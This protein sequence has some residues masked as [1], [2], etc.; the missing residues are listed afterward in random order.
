MFQPFNFA[1]V[2]DLHLSEHNGLPRLRQ[3]IE[4]IGAHRDI[5]FVLVLGDLMWES[6]P[7]QLKTILAGSGVPVHVMYGNNDWKWIKDGSYEKAF[8]P[9]DYS[10]TFANCRFILMWDCLPKD[11]AENHKGDFSPAQ[12]SWL[13][14]QLTTAQN[15]GMTHTFVATHVP[16]STPGAY[17]PQF[18]MFTYTEQRF[19]DLLEKYHA[20]AA[21][22]GHL[23]QNAAWK[24]GDIQCYLTP[25]CCWNF[26]SATRK[27]DSS[28]VRIVKVEQDQISA[29]LLPVHL[30]GETFIWETLPT[31]FDLVDSP[32]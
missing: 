19:F 26:V 21:L 29:E 27:V 31:F 25:S 15:D 24:Q 2:T 32:K 13:E 17:N 12:W 30:D 9:R 16:P 1:I 14:E 20:S 11:H 7:Q 10:F 4:L 8:G 5:A 28:F 22:F 23:H 18:F 6:D 3:A